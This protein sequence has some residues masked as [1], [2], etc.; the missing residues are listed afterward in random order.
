MH[1][2]CRVKRGSLGCGVQ[3]VYVTAIVWGPNVAGR[4]VGADK[5]GG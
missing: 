3:S 5:S 2:T 4:C 1:D